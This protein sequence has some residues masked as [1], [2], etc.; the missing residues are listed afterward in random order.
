MCSK[1]RAHLYFCGGQ[2]AARE[3]SWP[4]SGRGGFHSTQEGLDDCPERSGS[5]AMAK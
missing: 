2:R 1:R 3:L 5:S 4:K